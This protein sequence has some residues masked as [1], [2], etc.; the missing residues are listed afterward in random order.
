M[1]P[2]MAETRSLASL[3]M[4]T[5]SSTRAPRFVPSA[6][7]GV[8]LEDVAAPHYFSPFFGSPKS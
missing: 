6:R 4:R 7:G 8:A 3:S 2:G 5:H 1:Q